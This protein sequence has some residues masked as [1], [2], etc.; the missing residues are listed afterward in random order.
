MVEIIWLFTTFLHGGSWKSEVCLIR[1]KA[2]QKNKK[3]KKRRKKTFS[4]RTTEVIPAAK[5]K[6]EG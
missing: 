6:R 5:K 4:V 2:I 3:D 1:K